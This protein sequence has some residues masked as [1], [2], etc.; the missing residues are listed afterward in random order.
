MKITDTIYQVDDV[1]GGTFVL[2]GEQY[3]SLVD[4]GVPGSEG[5]VFALIESLGRKPGDL[6]HILL[7]H[8]DGDH[9][10]CLPA[11][12]EA[13]GAAVYAQRDEAEVI[14]G[15]RQSRGGSFVQKPV[16]VSRVVA[17]GD[18]LALHGGIQV[19]ESFGHTVGHVCYYLLSEKALIVGDCLVNLEGL[20]GSIPKYTY[21]A[22][23]AVATVKKLAALGPDSL[24]FGHGPA[25]VGGA[26]AALALLRDRVSA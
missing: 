21:N 7:T 8:S 2:V 6:K 24:C 10:G 13:T 1:F 16:K 20:S 12:V 23:Q 5:K 17:E 3:L 14:A 26:A 15:T 19:I 18:V 11:L 9:I 25:I 22:E 4:T